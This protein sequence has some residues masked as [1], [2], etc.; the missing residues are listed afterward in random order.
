MGIDRRILVMGCLVVLL[1]AFLF[2]WAITYG[3]LYQMAAYPGLHK[4]I[5]LDCQSGLYYIDGVPHAMPPNTFVEACA[6]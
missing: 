5:V 4:H 2:S 1:A 3:P 6:F